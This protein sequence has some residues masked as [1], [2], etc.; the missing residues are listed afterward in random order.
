MYR[1][2]LLKLSEKPF[3]DP[4]WLFE[5]KWDGDGLSPYVARGHVELRARS[6]QRYHSGISGMKSI[7]KQLNARQ[8]IV[9][10]EIVVLDAEGRSDFTRI[11]PRFGVSNP[12][13]SLQQKYPA[14]F[15]AYDLALLRWLRC[16]RRRARNQVKICCGELLAAL[17][18]HSLFRPCAGDRRRAYEIARER[19]LEGII[20]KRRDSRYVGS[21]LRCG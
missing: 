6:K 18:H 12:P 8:A 19:R 3:S 17:G 10:G 14:T 7:V 4:N 20:A 5:I 2:R 1:W 13:Q 11:Q 15:Y 9:D 21:G 16:A